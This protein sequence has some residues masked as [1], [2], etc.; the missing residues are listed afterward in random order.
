[1]P[2]EV[3]EQIQKIQEQQQQL[4]QLQT[5]Q[6][7][8][9]Q[10]T[11][12]PPITL[13]PLPAQASSSTQQLPTNMD[14]DADG[15]QILSVGADSQTRILQNLQGVEKAFRIPC[16]V[17]AGDGREIPLGR[18][19]TQADQGSEMN[20]I[21]EALRAQLQLP[22]NPLASVGFEGLTMHTADHRDT[23]LEYW[24]EFWV[25]TEGISRQVRCFVSPAINLPGSARSGHFSLLLGLPWLFSVNAHISIRD[26]KISVGDPARGETLREIKGPE[27]VFCNEHTLLMYPKKSLKATVEDAS[28]EDEEDTGSES[29]DELEDVEEV[30]RK[31]AFWSVPSKT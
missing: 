23:P 7:Q 18:G 27:M 30:P 6:S 14:A 28:S 29:E 3:Q 25:N 16:T 9:L 22:K 17:K 13:E 10:Q 26:S 11:I 20:V 4:Q 5:Q 15:V 12:P 31:L 8:T 1:M 2:K 24:T 21:S 19:V